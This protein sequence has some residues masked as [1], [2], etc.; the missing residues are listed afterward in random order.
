MTA[1]ERTFLMILKDAFH[2]EAL[3]SEEL[4][5]SENI[6][7]ETIMTIALKQHL[8]TLVYD[9]S[10]AY[11]SFENFDLVKPQYFTGAIASV[12]GQMQK[13]EAFL[14]LYRQFLEH[15]LKPITLKGIICR[16]LYGEKADFR[17][18]SDEDLM[19][20]KKDYEAAKNILEMC[21]YHTEDQPD[22]QLSIIQEV[23]FQNENLTIELHLNP[24]GSDSDMRQR[25]N[26]WFLHVF[27]SQE[28]VD[29]EDVSI[30]TMPPTDHFLF[31]VF[32]A[33]KHFTN[34]GFGIRMLLDILL[35]AEKYE[36][37]IDWRYIHN[38]LV[39]IGA[40]GF[41]GDLIYLGNTY[42]GFKI[43]QRE[44]TV[45]PDALL[46]DMFCMGIFGNSTSADQ[47]AGSIL[48]IMIEKCTTNK[49]EKKSIIHQG[50]AYLGLLFPSWEM[51]KTWKPYLSD[52]PW[53]IVV[54]WTKRVI[55]YLRG[56]TIVRDF[57][58]LEKSYEIASERLELLKKY[59]I[60]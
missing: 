36:Q 29:I 53:M 56:E 16:N 32:H 18:S 35:F 15:G 48:K 3:L 37:R 60:M 14:S 57:Q 25:M 22:Q 44:E 39:D 17:P 49:T 21:G 12:T 8:F 4:S 20:E 30:R 40:S 7:W 46:E 11:P 31:L 9:A 27:E 58:G 42:L 38:G 54:E 28:T 1:E 2:P 5:E 34:R 59:G 23:T 13:T 26:E 10:K 45:C 24:F 50:T 41:M 55:R 6:D 47:T 43:R 19:I 52:K 33:F 51:W